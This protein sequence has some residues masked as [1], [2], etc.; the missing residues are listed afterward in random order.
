[1]S[2]LV[3]AVLGASISIE[4]T[5]GRVIVS[6]GGH[7]V[8]DTTAAVTPV[9]WPRPRVH[10]FADLDQSALRR[11]ETVTYCPHKGDASYLS[12]DLG[13]NV[14]V[15]DVIWRYEEPFPAVVDR[16]ARRLLRGSRRGRVGADAPSRALAPA[17]RVAVGP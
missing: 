4:P 16:R 10:P 15:V 5:D 13:E 1:M 17:V 3:R 2:C 14:Q 8:A 9:C 11:S 7:V 12:V 6:V